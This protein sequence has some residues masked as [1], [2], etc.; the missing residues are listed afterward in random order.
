MSFSRAA[1]SA[2]SE[3][4]AR[5]MTD[6]LAAV[7]DA[8]AAVTEEINC[9]GAAWIARPVIAAEMMVAG[10]AIPRLENN[11]RSFSNALETRFCAPSSVVP[12]TSPISRKLFVSKKRSA[13]AF[14][15]F[16]LRLNRAPSSKGAICV[17]AES[18]SEEHRFMASCS[19]WRR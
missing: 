6:A 9:A 7:S 11:W 8:V 3:A 12:S 15:S 1:T 2:S 18:D 14:R 5:A 13:T 19:V 16:S 17:Q 4:L 10:R